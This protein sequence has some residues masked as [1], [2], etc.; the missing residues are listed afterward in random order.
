MPRVA[1]RDSPRTEPGPSAQPV[2][3]DRLGGVDAATGQVP[4]RG[5]ATGTPGRLVRGDRRHGGPIQRGGSPRRRAQQVRRRSGVPAGH[6]D[7]GVVSGTRVAGRRPTAR[8]MLASRSRPRSAEVPAAAA[9]SARTTTRAP[10]GK[11]WSR[12]ASCARRRRDTRCRCTLPPTDLPTISPTC[13]GSNRPS[14]G[15]DPTWASTYTNTAPDRPRRPAR[16]TA[17]KSADRRRRCTAGSTAGPVRQ[18]DSSERPFRRRAVRMAR[19]ARVRMRNRKPWVLARRRLFGWK[20]RLLTVWLHHGRSRPRGGRSRRGAG[21]R[22]RPPSSVLTRC[23]A[24]GCTSTTGNPRRR[25]T[26]EIPTIRTATGRGQTRGR[27]GPPRATGSPGACDTPYH[28]N[29]CRNLV[30]PGIV[31]RLRTLLRCRLETKPLRI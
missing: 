22:E 27:A 2:P 11:P 3:R 29:T 4:A 12:L 9:G 5:R 8:R 21:G 31:A 14:A 19:P 13:T 16:V 6:D 28:A 25:P 24:Q 23:S 30:T 1:P 7:T 26:H 20:V 10:G 15:P 17:P 18:A